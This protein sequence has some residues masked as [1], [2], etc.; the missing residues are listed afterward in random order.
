VLLKGYIQSIK[1]TSTRIETTTNCHICIMV[2]KGALKNL[3]SETKLNSPVRNATTMEND[4]VNNLKNKSNSKSKKANAVPT[5]KTISRR[6]MAFGTIPS[7]AAEHEAGNSFMEEYDKYGES[8]ELVNGLEGNNNLNNNRQ[9]F[10]T[11]ESSDALSSINSTISSEFGNYEVIEYDL[12][13][14][15]GPYQDGG[16]SYLNL[17]PPSVRVKSK[18]NLV[19]NPD[20]ATSLFPRINFLIE[21]DSPA[22]AAVRANAQIHVSTVGKAARAVHLQSIRRLAKFAAGA[23]KTGYRKGKPPRLPPA[24]AQNHHRR[25]ADGPFGGPGRHLSSG[26]IDEGDEIDAVSEYDEG[27]GQEEYYTADSQDDDEDEINN[28][29]NDG[30][31]DKDLESPTAEIPDSSVVRDVSIPYLGN[32]HHSES[33]CADD[34]VRS[35]AD[36][37]S[38]PPSS[39]SLTQSNDGNILVTNK[40]VAQILDEL[41]QQPLNDKVNTNSANCEQILLQQNRSNDSEPKHQDQMQDLV[42]MKNAGVSNAHFNDGVAQGTIEAGKKGTYF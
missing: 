32:K 7:R 23:N 35:K 8:V 22:A 3:A 37:R 41:S 31:E 13:D 25:Y 18:D 28:L 42:A 30:E 27:E 2:T 12:G 19:T 4:A 10:S 5:K 17:S 11:E 33:W 39:P 24:S 38:S 16:I 20:E 21:D 34:P 1:G 26:S 36:T 14:P 9:D 6:K 29:K 40:I 15:N